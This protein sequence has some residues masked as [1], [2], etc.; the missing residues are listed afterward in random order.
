MK[1]IFAP[2]GENWGS[3]S[4]WVE[5]MILEGALILSDELGQEFARCWSRT[6]AFI[7]QSTAGTR[8]GDLLSVRVRDG[9]TFGY[10]S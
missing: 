9:Q 4:C 8:N 3:T 2:S 1:T 6:R 7:D 10:P 5:A